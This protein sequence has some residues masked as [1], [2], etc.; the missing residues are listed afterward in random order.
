MNTS[1]TT[2]GCDRVKRKL[3]TLA[4]ERFPEAHRVEAQ[5]YS[6]IDPEGLMER[7]QLLQVQIVV[8][9]PDWDSLNGGGR[10]GFSNH[11]RPKL[12]V[13]GNIRATHQLFGLA[14]EH[15]PPYEA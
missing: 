1:P 11:L 8:D 9:T 4:K 3:E 12:V 10:M 2:A 6:E 5:V 7:R 14:C 13:T 15:G